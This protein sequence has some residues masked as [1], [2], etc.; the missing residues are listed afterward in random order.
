[1]NVFTSSWHTLCHGVIS[2]QCHPQT[3]PSMPWSA[4]QSQAYKIWTGLHKV[5]LYIIQLVQCRLQISD[6]PDYHRGETFMFF[7]VFH[8]QLQIFSCELWPCRLAVY[9]YKNAT[10]NVFLQVVIFH[11]KCKSCPLRQFCGVWY[12]SNCG[13]I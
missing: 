3:K 6:Y 12:C 2:V 13:L 11:P 4:S 1:M 9:V 10:A 8:T 5:H 7:M